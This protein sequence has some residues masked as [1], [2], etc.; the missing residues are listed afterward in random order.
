M[1]CLTFCAL[2]F[3]LPVSGLSYVLISWLA[4]SASF[5]LPIRCSLLVQLAGCTPAQAVWGIAAAPPASC[6][7][8]G[9]MRGAGQ[10]LITVSG[11]ALFLVASF[12]L[13]LPRRTSKCFSLHRHTPFTHARQ[14][15]PH[16]PLPSPSHQQC[17]VLHSAPS[18]APPS[19]SC[20][21]CCC[22][23]SCSCCR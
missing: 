14:K 17:T 22:G 6:A 3:W 13:T 16:I 11:P 20:R 1:S 2:G 15:N 7:T 12:L 18:D 19:S 4:G 8:T 5:V 23:F 21:G 9:C 10:P